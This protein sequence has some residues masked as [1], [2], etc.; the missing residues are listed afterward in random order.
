MGLRF[1]HSTSIIEVVSP[2]SSE[3]V[4]VNFTQSF[5]HIITS[6]VGYF[7]HPALLGPVLCNNHHLKGCS[8]QSFVALCRRSRRKSFLR[9][10][11]SHYRGCRLPCCR[12]SHSL[13]QYQGKPPC[14][15]MWEVRANRVGIAAA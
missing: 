7:T 6:S 1:L 10:S 4:H 15:E 2:L 12:A 3:K 13:L 8:K 9:P 11:R 5:N 14:R